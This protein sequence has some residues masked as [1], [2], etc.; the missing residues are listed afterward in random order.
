M[1][2]L[3]I[4]HI[5]DFGAAN[6][7]N[8]FASLLALEDELEA[9][10]GC[11]V[12]VL[13]ARAENKYWAK[14]LLRDGKKLFFMSG[15][16]VA[17]ASMIRR[18]MNEY[19]ITAIHSHFAHSYIYL[20]LRLTRTG[21]FREIPF[22]VHVHSQYKKQPNAIKDKLRD[23]IISEAEY[24]CVSKS[25]SEPFERRGRSFRVVY[26][27]VD[28]SRL[29]CY[30]DIRDKIMAGRSGKLVLMFGYDFRIKGVDIALKALEKFD[31][32]HRFTLGI[33]V[34][35]HLDRAKTQLETMFGKIPEWVRLLPARDDVASYYKA[36]DVFLSA[37]RT[38]G[39][40]YALVEAAYCK[41]PVAAADIPGQNELQSPNITFFRPVCEASLFQA[42]EAAAS[43]GASG[44]QARE[45]VVERFPIKRWTQEIIEIYN[46]RQAEKNR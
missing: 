17:D 28:F 18:V 31:T 1:A 41:T 30:E 32:N 7:G 16:I 13:P 43:A 46:G 9:L 44:E 11:A 10:G 40:P 14:D 45:Y 26:N 34:T 24:I 15:S 4:L 38:E 8:F 22:Y 37:S 6:P 42:V 3:N 5:A 35:N 19:D 20:A 39:F 33:V 29:Y 23:Y 2:K 27:A 25:V 36:A 12:Y 21:R